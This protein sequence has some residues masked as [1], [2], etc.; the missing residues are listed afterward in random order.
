MTIQEFDT[1]WDEIL[2]SM[3]QFP[4]EDILESLSKLRIR[5]SEKLRRIRIVQ[6]RDLSEEIDT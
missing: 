5:V 2:L 4:P 1:R 6:L 3:E